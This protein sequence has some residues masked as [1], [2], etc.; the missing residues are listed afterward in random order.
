MSHH[1]S[2]FSPQTQ[3]PTAPSPSTTFQQGDVTVP[4]S[5]V[6]KLAFAKFEARGGAHGFDK[7]DWE[8]ASRE[9]AAKGHRRGHPAGLTPLR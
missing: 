3:K 6:A 4:D 1:E 5:D 9:L 7:E 2:H 8:N